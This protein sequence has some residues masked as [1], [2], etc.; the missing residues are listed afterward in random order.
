M[1]TSSIFESIELGVTDYSR[2]LHESLTLTDEDERNI[3]S[4]WRDKLIQPYREN[5]NRPELIGRKALNKTLTATALRELYVLKKNSA[6]SK[7]DKLSH[8]LALVLKRYTCTTN[9][10]RR[11]IRTLL[12]Q[13]MR[14]ATLSCRHK[15]FNSKY[16]YK[17]V[18]N[19]PYLYGSLLARM[20]RLVTFTSDTVFENQS[21]YSIKVSIIGDESEYC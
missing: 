12:Q 15:N 5:L 21:I 2:K 10:T 14:I 9:S 13:H 8:N 20:R 11:F 4:C 16:N 18:D 1:S 19:L 3:A 7:V 6:I 17:H